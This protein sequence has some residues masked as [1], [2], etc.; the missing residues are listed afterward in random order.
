M[1]IFGHSYTGSKFIAKHTATCFVLLQMLNCC[2]ERK[3][4]RESSEADEVREEE[5]PNSGVS[6]SEYSTTPDSGISPAATAAHTDTKVTPSNDSVT[7][8]AVP[9][10]DD[11][12]DSSPQQSSSSQNAQQQVTDDCNDSAKSDAKRHRSDSSL[13][14]DDDDDDDE[15]FECDDGED[16]ADESA[17]VSD[18]SS[19]SSPVQAPARKVQRSASSCKSKTKT[20]VATC[21]P[22]HDAAAAF[23]RGDVTS[24]SHSD[25]SLDSAAVGAKTA[26]NNVDVSKSESGLKR[27][28]GAAV[29]GVTPHKPASTVVT[30]S[31]VSEASLSSVQS[32]SSTPSDGSF[33]DVYG[34]QPEGRLK[35][36]DGGLRLLNNEREFVYIPVTQET[37]PMTEDTLDE[38]AEVLTKYVD[39]AAFK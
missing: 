28:S 34:H 17:A 31:G 33:L 7:V 2:I 12:V 37:A 4:A 13:T 35:P 8:A 9:K 15:F 32:P 10:D 25:S 21:K 22:Q 18:S 3:I 24:A 1:S 38:H 5:E 20:D 16:I 14:S 23:D 11:S 39:V 29:S 27:D 6:Q 26:H 19:P 30:D 36:C